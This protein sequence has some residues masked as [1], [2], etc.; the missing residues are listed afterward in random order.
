MRRPRSRKLERECGVTR[1]SLDNGALLAARRGPPV[2]V[3][4][5]CGRDPSYGVA[6]FCLVVAAFSD[7]SRH[8]FTGFSWGYGGEGPRGLERW[9]QENGVPL[10][11]EHIARLDNET[12]GTV[13]TWPRA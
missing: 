12:A 1:I 13:W 8:S 11:I 4:L 2:R 10:T 5:R 6:E 3:E 9:C 7:G